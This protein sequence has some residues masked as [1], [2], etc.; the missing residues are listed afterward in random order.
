MTEFSNFFPPNFSGAVTN[1][2]YPD[3]FTKEEFNR[4][5]Y[6]IMDSHVPIWQSW[7]CHPKKAMF[8]N[9][10]THEFLKDIITRDSVVSLG[11][12]GLDYSLRPE[13]DLIEKQKEVFAIQCGLAVEANKPLVIHCRNAQEDCLEILKKHVPHD[14]K[15]HCHCF[16][17]SWEDCQ[18]KWMAH[19]KNIYI[20]LT[21]VV[22]YPSAKQQ[23]EVANNLPLDRLLLETDS[24][25]FVPR[26][27]PQSAGIVYS[28]PGMA[29]FTASAIAEIRVVSLSE[30]VKATST[31]AKRMYNIL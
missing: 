15:I 2:C 1:F 10:K 16:M 14:Y 5:N 31:N 19:Y 25:Y 30:V 27:L 12:I 26:R 6:R 28:N 13:P 20:G 9:R 17:G 29:L 18:N 3:T 21:N 7:G 11:E 22:G 4:W 24:P 23:H 8:Y